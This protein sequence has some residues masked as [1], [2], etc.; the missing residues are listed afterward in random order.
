MTPELEILVHISAPSRVID[1]RK[2]RKQ[3]LGFLN[4]EAATRLEV[5]PCNEVPEQLVPVTPYLQGLERHAS[6]AQPLRDED[7]QHAS[8]YPRVEST[9]YEELS[10]YGS[11][12]ARTYHQSRVPATMYTTP[13]VIVDRTPAM[14]RPQTAPVPPSPSLQGTTHRRSQSDS[15]QTLPSVIPDSQPERSQLKRSFPESVSFSSSVGLSSPS[16]KRQR[17]NVA[18]GTKP[19]DPQ[20][21]AKSAEDISATNPGPTTD[22]SPIWA[23]SSPVT[24]DGQGN[25]RV[26]V[27]PLPPKTSLASFAT[28][29]TPSLALIEVKLPM[30][31]FYNPLITN[32]DVL[33]LER[34]YWQLLLDQ[35]VEL[36]ERQKFWEFLEQFIREGRAGWGVWAE[37][38]TEK[39]RMINEEVALEGESRDV[40][41]EIV[42]V[43]C[44]G[45]VVGYIYILLFMGSHRKI[46]GMDAMWV[47]AGGNVVV[48]MGE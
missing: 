21:S 45:E 19:E 35:K 1:D 5:G 30:A 48:R 20:R 4:F 34:G 17:W 12:A 23:M 32:R 43:Y 2:Y 41:D 24:P 46:K 22:S 10:W 38:F 18:D 7:D 31:R 27:H 13:R 15:W 39:R 44:W 8:K 14:A 42:K 29:I 9:F 33:T 47:D 11:V 40:D 26:E 36:D 28:H 3:A 37:K 6:L 16:A 25:G